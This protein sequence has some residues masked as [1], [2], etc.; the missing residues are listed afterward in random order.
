ML[1]YFSFDDE[2]L[3]RVDDRKKA[4]AFLC[5]LDSTIGDPGI[6]VV[7]DDLAEALAQIRKVAPQ[8]AQ[9]H[10]FR[11]LSAACRGR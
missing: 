10:R 8:L 7:P 1:E 4:A 11:R 3:A 2:P 5:L 6:F 9:D